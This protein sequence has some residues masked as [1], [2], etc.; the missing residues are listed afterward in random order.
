MYLLRS[1]AHAGIDARTPGFY[2]LGFFR[3]IVSLMFMMHGSGKL[4]GFPVMPSSGSTVEF[5]AWPGWWSGLIEFGAG[6]FVLLGLGTRVAALLCSGAMAY[7]YLVVH[8]KT[9]LWPI[10]NGGELAVMYCW[11]FFLLAFTGPGAFA[12]DT[13]AG[14][15]R[16]QGSGRRPA[17]V[18]V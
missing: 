14:M 13:R 18:S 15:R 8:Q 3:V 10:E 2:V 12:L 4:F 9:G 7:A 17:K 11:S 16:R 5:G 1:D 6:A